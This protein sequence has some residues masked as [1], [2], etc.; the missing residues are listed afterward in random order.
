MTDYNLHAGGYIMTIWRGSAWEVN[1]KAE[2]KRLKIPP[3]CRIL[4]IS[5]IHG[6]C[7]ILRAFLKKPVFPKGTFFLSLAT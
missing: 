4:A 2:V 3:G 7:R 6:N 5:D 1:L